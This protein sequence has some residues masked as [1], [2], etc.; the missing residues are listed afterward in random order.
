MRRRRLLAAPLAAL[1]CLGCVGCAT[2]LPQTAEAIA[3]ATFD[4]L[5]L[6]LLA[7]LEWMWGLFGLIL[8]G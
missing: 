1:V 6:G 5:W 3:P 8:G 2:A 7:D 4:D